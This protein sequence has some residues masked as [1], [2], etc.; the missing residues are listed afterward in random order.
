VRTNDTASVAERLA[1]PAGR[2]L[3]AVVGALALARRERPMHPRGVLLDGTLVA[4]DERAASVLP[5]PVVDV[6]V[7]LSLSVGLPRPLPDVVGIA[8]RWTDDGAPQDVLLASTGRGRLTRYVLVPRRRLAGGWLTTMM[9]LR[10][11]WGPV[12]LALRPLTASPG[13]SV[14]FEVLQAPPFGAWTRFGTLELHGP[15]TGSSPRDGD[16]PAVRFDPGVNAPRRLGAYRWE[17]L[18]RNPAYVL[19]RRLV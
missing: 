1:R 7:R 6:L 3:A 13:R 16:D 15:R 12:V 5:T 10:A 8:L 11:P 2:V 4:A 14:T 17:E 9:P 18:L 19:A